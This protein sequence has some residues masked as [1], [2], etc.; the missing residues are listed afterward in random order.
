[1]TLI[2][3]GLGRPQPFRDT[4]SKKRHCSE[5]RGLATSNVVVARLDRAT[6]YAVP[7]RQA[8]TLAEY[9]IARFRESFAEVTIGDSL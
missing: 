5:S 8:R 4:H 3:F 6:Q 7:S 9:W 2:S 1:M